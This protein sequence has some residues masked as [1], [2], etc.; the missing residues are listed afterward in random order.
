[1]LPVLW[2]KLSKVC[3]IGTRQLST[4]AII[5]SIVEILNIDHQ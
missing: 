1:M 5:H 2:P 3:S 4:P